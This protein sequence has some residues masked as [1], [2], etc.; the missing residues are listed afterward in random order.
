VKNGKTIKRESAFK[1]M[2]GRQLDNENGSQLRTAIDWSK[3]DSGIAY[4]LRIL[5]DNGIET[6]ESCQGGQ[7]HPF[8]VPTIRFCGGRAAGFKAVEIAVTYGLKMSELRRVWNMQDGELT[9]PE[10]E[11]T[12]Y[13]LHSRLGGGL[14]FVP[15]RDGS[16]TVKCRWV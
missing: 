2:N 1:T 5:R 10:W 6:T 9:G 13:E 14:R 4:E 15:K 12:F 8:P 11:I 7:G 16:G 3:I